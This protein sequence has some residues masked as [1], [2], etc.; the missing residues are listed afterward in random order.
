MEST[1]GTNSNM[2]FKFLEGQPLPLVQNSSS[3]RSSQILFLLTCSPGMNNTWKILVHMVSQVKT[4]TLQNNSSVEPIHLLFC[5][6]QKEAIGHLLGNRWL[7]SS[8]TTGQQTLSQVE[9]GQHL[10]TWGWGCFSSSLQSQYYRSSCFH[11][12]RT[13]SILFSLTGIVLCSLFCKSSAIHSSDFLLS[14]MYHAAMQ[15]IVPENIV[16]SSLLA[17][18]GDHFSWCIHSDF[19]YF[20]MVVARQQ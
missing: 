14:S 12:G 6:A 1:C 17:V 18:F 5:T 4:S 8:N 13:F 9:D 2:S 7:R 11:L 20:S 10:S 16:F 15:I 3:C 19:C